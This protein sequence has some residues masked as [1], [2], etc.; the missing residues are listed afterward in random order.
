MS[1][2]N[3]VPMTPE[4]AKAVLEAE[5]KKR[6]NDCGQAVKEAL[7]KHGCTISVSMNLSEAGIRP[8]IS[9]VPLKD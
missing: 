5:Q 6:I 1:D 8:A 3:V 2:D 4:S 7:D 9:I